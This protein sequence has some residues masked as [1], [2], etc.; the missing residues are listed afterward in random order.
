MTGIADFP[1]DEHDRRLRQLHS[2]LMA[3]IVARE[4]GA[5]IPDN[6]LTQTLTIAGD[7]AERCHDDFDKIVELVNAGEAVQS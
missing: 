5:G 7:L 1:F 6:Y 3:L 4:E 2:L